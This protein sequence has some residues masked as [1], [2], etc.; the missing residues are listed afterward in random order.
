[1]FNTSI[2]PLFYDTENA[3]LSDDGE[4]GVH[5]KLSR[6]HNNNAEVAIVVTR[7]T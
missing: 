3:H 7:E 2:H 5:R 4:S 6:E 1:M